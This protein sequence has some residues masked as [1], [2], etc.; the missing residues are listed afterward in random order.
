MPTESAASGGN[1]SSN[2]TVAV[3]V[4]PLSLKEKA[5]Q[6]WATVEVLDATHV[7][8][9]DCLPIG[10]AAKPLARIGADSE[11]SLRAAFFFSIA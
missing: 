6:S 5:R 3:R 10:A 8:V 11:P 1:S 4:R 2:L 7:L 9:R